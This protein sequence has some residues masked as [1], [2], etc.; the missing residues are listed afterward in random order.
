MAK[1][2]DSDEFVVLSRV[3]TGLKREFA[4]A[5]K[6]QSEICGGSL[7]RTRASKNRVEAPVQPA[8]A[9]KRSRKSEEAK[10]L[11]DAMSEEEVK[12]DVVDLQSDDEP[13]NNNHVG[14]SESA[15]MQVCEEEPKSD[16]VL[17][18]L[19]SEEQPKML[20]PESV[21]SEEEPKVLDDVINEEEAIVAE[22]LKEQEPIVPETLKEEV[23]DEMAEQPLCIEESE[24]KDSNG[25]A[26]ALVNDGAKGKKS[27]KKR[28]ERP[29]SER[30]FTRSAL[31]V[32]SEETNDGEHVGV[33]GISD[34]VKRETEAG[35]SLVMT[36]PSSVKFS[37]RR[38]LK[39]FPAKLRDL[40]AT[41]ILEGLPVM[42]MKG[43][44]VL[45]GSFNNNH[46]F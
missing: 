31:K 20:E 26:L 14:E 16:V 21:I 38:K 24:E 27:M 8:S 34:G 4:F 46:G 29:Q 39:K 22:T 45:F 12:S 33:A 37:N 28:L 1:G 7:G 5:M 11:E 35:A 32:K 23:V 9:R 6:A 19:I 43:A 18:T 25:V 3:R 42:Y 2:A 40:L 15:A 10:T 44:K 41:G 30:R 13:K 36:T 17:E